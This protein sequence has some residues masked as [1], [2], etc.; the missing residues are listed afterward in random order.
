MGSPSRNPYARVRAGGDSSYYFS[1]PINRS[2]R[3]FQILGMWRSNAI[4]YTYFDHD[5]AFV[6]MFYYYV[7]LM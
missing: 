7:H 3:R 1:E 5:N 4:G 2:H 6:D